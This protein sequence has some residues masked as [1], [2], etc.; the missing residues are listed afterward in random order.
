MTFIILHSNTQRKRYF[1]H[2]VAITTSQH[3]K[4]AFST[5]PL[6]AERSPQYNLAQ[7]L[8]FSTE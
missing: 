8:R 1:R 2:Q 3:Q 4:G 5:D 7:T 6:S